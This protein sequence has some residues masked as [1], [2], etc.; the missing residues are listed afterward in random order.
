MTS[1]TALNM[2]SSPNAPWTVLVHYNNTDDLQTLIAPAWVDTPNIRSTMDI[3]QSCLL[4]LFACIYTAL[5]LDVPTKTAWHRVLLSKVG[6]VVITLFSPEISL[7]MAADQLQQAWKLKSNLR[8]IRKKHEGPEYEDLGLNIDL[9]YA[10]F[11]IMG[12]VRAGVDN[13]LS[14]PD[15]DEGAFG[16]NSKLLPDS[17]R[18]GP[19]GVTQLAERGH[20]IRISEKRI[21][22]KSKADTLQKILV[23]I[24]VSWMVMQCIARRVNDLPLSLLEIHTM[25]HVV[26]ALVLYICWFKKP[27][28]VHDP[29]VTNPRDFKGEIALML[30]R[31][32]YSKLSNKL[33]LFPQKDSPDQP[34]P[35]EEESGQSMR[36]IERSLGS[37]LDQFFNRWDAI[38]ETYPFE[39]R[40]E[41]ANSTK[42]IGSSDSPSYKTQVLFL[43]RL[44][45]FSQESKSFYRNLPFS[46]GKS[47]IDID[48][49]GSYDPVDSSW[50]IEPIEF[51]FNY[52]WL[53]LLAVVLSAA[54]GGIHLTA[55]NSVFP[56]HVEKLLW[57][58]S[59][60]CVAA[61]PPI[62]AGLITALTLVANI[63]EPILDYISQHFFDLVGY[64]PS[65]LFLDMAVSI[66]FTAPFWIAYLLYMVSRVYIIVEV[67]ISLRHV[68]VGVY[69]SPSW[70]QMI[71]HF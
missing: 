29:E 66:M 34:P 61:M 45:D 44:E 48:I 31:Q 50:I 33:A 41:L 23:V 53:L 40:V 15:L 10:F 12:G 62:F 11:I 38:L 59:C 5:H 58:I 63:S 57:K 20:W 55:W 19:K 47:N 22:D 42:H 51:W 14:L 6:W 67:F 24:Q 32:F 64:H 56:N 16:H 49:R 68:P 9:R 4:T 43:A 8:A 52:P 28:N 39:N 71:P 36:W 18:L 54:Y 35:R 27:L 1:P 13:M 70:V 37:K 30:Q 26:C 69:V 2:S 7:Y 46:E 65:D 17:V 25:V 3:L 21:D 60:I